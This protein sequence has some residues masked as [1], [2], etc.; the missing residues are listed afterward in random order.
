M[1]NEI[2]KED[3]NR[4]QDLKHNL[5]QTTFHN[6]SFI[7][8]DLKRLGYSNEDSEKLACR[9]SVKISYYSD[10]PVSQHQDTYHKTRPNLQYED[11]S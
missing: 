2:T 11:L 4:I 10:L 5:N 7:Y 3:F 9:Y 8:N 1:S 6:Y